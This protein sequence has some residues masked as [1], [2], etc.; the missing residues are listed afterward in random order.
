VALPGLEA[1]L[2][3]KR[4][5][6]KTES[7]VTDCDLKTSKMPKETPT[8]KSMLIIGKFTDGKYR[9]IVC[10]KST[11]AYLLDMIAVLHGK[12]QVIEKEI[13]GITFESEVDLTEK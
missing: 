8:I 5:E 4:K 7:N 3:A 10:D 1:N 6:A 9:Q 13:E 2:N 11:Q 12:I